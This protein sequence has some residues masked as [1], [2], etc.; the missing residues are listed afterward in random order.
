MP[1]LSKK[2]I[3]TIWRALSELET[4]YTVT[5]RQEGKKDGVEWEYIEEANNILEKAILEED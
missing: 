5:V 1:E 4:A 3:L 2:A